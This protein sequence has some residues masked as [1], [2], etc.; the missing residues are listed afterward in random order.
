MTLGKEKNVRNAVEAEGATLDEAIA[1]ALKELQ[2]ERERVEIEILAQAT[3]GFLGIGGKKARVRATLRVPLA[4]RST[5]IVAE[6]RR[7]REQRMET[8]V[9]PVAPGSAPISPE[10]GERARAVLK[11]VLRLMGTDAALTLETHGEEAIL[12]VQEI[13]DAAEGFLIG[14]RGQTL[15]ALEYLLNRMITKSEE[16]DA[17]IAVDIEGY[18]ARRWKS[19]E[20]LA[21]RLGERAKRRRKTVTLSPMSPRDRRV[22]HLTLE[23]DPLL[24]TKSMGRGYFRQVCIIPEQGPRR[25][26]GRGSGRTQTVES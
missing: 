20:S 11:E 17:H 10:M 19:L 8:V 25:E 2:T 26:R 3:K 23:A 16:T 12:N 22:I 18:R 7:Q 13:S 4:I 1:N 9:E 14:H 21:L 15:D 5:E 6:P 24:T